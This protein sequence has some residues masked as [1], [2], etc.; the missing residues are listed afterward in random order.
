[1]LS[2]ATTPTPSSSTSRIHGTKSGSIIVPPN[3][4]SPNTRKSTAIVRSSRTTCSPS[5]HS[6]QN[7]ASADSASCATSAT[8]SS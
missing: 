1:M 5:R 4:I 8:L 3:V 2:T 6:R 7:D